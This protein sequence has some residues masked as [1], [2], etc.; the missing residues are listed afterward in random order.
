[1]TASGISIYPNPAT[2]QISIN[3][4]SEAVANI[5]DASSRL[6]KTVMVQSGINTVDVSTFAPGIYHVEMVKAGA[7]ANYKLV[8]SK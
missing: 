2:S 8:I 6:V 4:N 7:K 5:F 1:M 3:S